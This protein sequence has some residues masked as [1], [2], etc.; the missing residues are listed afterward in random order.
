MSKVFICAAIP[1]ELATREEGAVAVATAIEAGDE[2]R[3]RA[4]FHWQFLEHYPAAQDC[5]YKFL[6]CEDKPGTHRPALDSW[7]AEYMLE[8]RWDEESAS[9]VP[10]ETESDPMN[11][12]FDKLSPEVQNAVMV[13][14]DTCENITVDMVISAQE[15]LQEDMAT[16]DGHIVEA[17]MKMPE[18]NAMYPEIKLHAIGWV[19][20]KCKPGAKWPEIQAEMRIWKKR[21]EGERKE[22]GKYTSVVDLARTRVNQHLTENSAAKINPVTT[23]IRREYRQTWKTL[24]KELACA[25]WP[26]DVD[27]GNIDGTIHR[28]A[29][30][31]VIDKDREDWKR[32]SASMRKQPDALR[33]DRQTIFGLVRER[34]IDI[35]KDPVALNKYISEYL[36]T[37]G[38]FEHEETDQSS[39]DA[40]LSSAA[41]TDPVETAESNSQK[42]EILVE[43][44]P[45]VERE[46][47][48][49][50][51]FTDKDG[52]KYGRA[53]KLS[54]LD[55]ALAAGG[56]EISKEEYFARKNGTYT[57]LQQNT[58]TAE[59]SEQ[60]EPVKVTADEVNKIMQAANI[61]QPDTDKLLAASRG[62][63]VE[64]I[65]DPNDPKWVKGIET[66]D[67][68]NQNQPESEQN[69][70][71]AE[72]NSPNALQNEPET[73]LPEPEV[74]Q[75]PEKVCTACG[76]TGDG[77]CPDCGAVMGDATY[78]E[79]FDEKNQAE[80]QEDDSEE[81]E[82]A[83]H[84][85]NENAGND[86][87]HTS[88]SETGEA[89]EPLIAENGHHIITSTSRVWI[90]L[91]VDLE[92]M[93]TNPDAPI[94]SI[95][96]KFFDPA[97]GEMGPEFSKAIDLETS[98]GIID[99]KTIKWWA[100]RSREAQSAIFTD[101]ISLDVA[102]RLFIEFIEK[103]SGGRFVQ[104]WGNG[105]N[106]DNVIL[107][108]SY[109]R[110]GIPCPWLYYNDRDVRT[111]VE[112]G[113]AIGFDVRMA[114]PFEGVPHNALDDAR[115]QAKQVS[116]IWQKLIPSQAD[117]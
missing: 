31:E 28:W 23:A 86:Q 2:R 102:L 38:V 1:D 106:F 7:D 11:V 87:H 93:G 113:N 74:Q 21:R 59:D 72:Q 81:M 97:T 75:E 8:N 115:H 9:F 100:K 4:K 22:T 6:V 90:H 82:G 95:G 20:H 3:A 57:G 63:F 89:A 44:E 66:R 61:S 110:Q 35:Y 103:N 40:I 54:G 94:N 56:T 32:I 80:V 51:V 84:P 104:V 105:A 34:P 12:T 55:K 15:L 71:K 88:D 43:A 50:F 67:S 109:E 33:Y 48:F 116:A 49:Y 30:N 26:G 76:Q 111:I 18:V 52:E 36:T 37:K 92:T 60:P 41:Q 69:D 24:D 19:K 25:L 96:G 108:R 83:E 10:V 77:N 98:G 27:A 117:F 58:D 13:K 62:E 91:S 70:Q 64:G 101:E 45:S 17:L 114:I 79:T 5:A 14:F 73:K 78:Q 42:N 107:R 53:N 99:R 85:N 68:V 46:G 65:S 112:L 47:P 16:F 39:A 29:K